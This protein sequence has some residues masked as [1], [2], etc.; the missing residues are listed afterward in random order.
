MAI[1][2][3]NGKSISNALDYIEYFSPT[4]ILCQR[5]L[6]A[7]FLYQHFGFLSAVEYVHARMFYDAAFGCDSQFTEPGQYVTSNGSATALCYHAEK[8]AISAAL[9]QQESAAL[10]RELWN[11]VQAS[12]LA[13]DKPQKTELFIMLTAA[14]SLAGKTLKDCPLTPEEAQSAYLREAPPEKAMDWIC[15]DDNDSDIILRARKK[16]YRILLSEE[17]AVDR[18][19]KG[20]I[21]KVRKF[22]VDDH[23]QGNR[24]IP[25]TLH[26]Y[27]NK[28]DPDPHRLSLYAHD[29]RYINC[30]DHI[31]IYIHPIES[32]S[33][34]CS[35][36]RIGNKLYI[37]TVPTPQDCSDL[38]IFGFVAEEL[39]QGCI[40][41]GKEGLYDYYYSKKNMYSTLPKK[42]IVQAVFRGNECLLLNNKGQVYSTNKDALDTGSVVATL[43][44]YHQIRKEL[45]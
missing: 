1:F 44:R 38:N 18:L 7:G 29:Y 6:A 12:D 11:M 32:H 39:Q 25:L 37:P 8:R 41:L 4:D 43:E 28:D 9:E 2:H 17:E 3:M 13:D 31:P 30:V 20:S 23:V 26:I 36:E 27:K 35:V 16:P 34:Q 40:L 21:I 22:V 45:T 42:D 15:L 19:K 5:E 33:R 10:R 14:Y 24:T